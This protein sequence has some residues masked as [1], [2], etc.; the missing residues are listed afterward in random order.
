MLLV[1][2]AHYDPYSIGF[3]VQLAYSV[4]VP[5]F[6]LVSGYLMRSDE[7]LCARDIAREARSILVPYA[8]AV[9]VCFI[10][11]VIGG[12]AV[13]PHASAA[14]D[15]PGLL[16]ELASGVV[17]QAPSL[18]LLF[19][20]M[21]IHGVG[22]LWFMQV[23][24]WSKVWI[25]VL[26]AVAILL[27]A[28]FRRHGH[29]AGD[30][31]NATDGNGVRRAGDGS[32]AGN[33]FSAGWNAA[34]D[35][36]SG[37][38]GGDGSAADDAGGACVRNH[39]DGDDIARVVACGNRRTGAGHGIGTCGASALPDPRVAASTVLSVLASVG[40]CFAISCGAVPDNMLM[41]KAVSMLAF[42]QAGRLLRAMEPLHANRRMLLLVP[43]WIALSAV[44]GHTD[45]NLGVYGASPVIAIACGIAGSVG[46]SA[47]IRMVWERAEG[48]PPWNGFVEWVGRETVTI[49]CVH[50]VEMFSTPWVYSLARES[51]PPWIG[52]WAVPLIGT[53]ACLATSWLWVIVRAKLHARA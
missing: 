53:V 14:R 7:H 39:A 2:L 13:A 49:A 29:G 10:A 35:G 28:P 48:C 20:G 45:Y 46:V 32:G 42:L 50:S 38:G 43:V 33:E 40:M 27:S 15:V 22:A 11:S 3:P 36:N 21:L 34:L 8:A 31:R 1:M 51:V 5:L 12:F 6:F 25:L 9:F 4:H 19:L 52:V 23:L 44:C 24:F 26:D 18:V 41:A 30:D 37:A 47:L 17:S 16:A